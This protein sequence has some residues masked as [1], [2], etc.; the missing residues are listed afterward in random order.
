MTRRETQRR[1]RRV[2]DDLACVPWLEVALSILDRDTLN[3]DNYC[4]K[5]GASVEV[6]N[7]VEMQGPG[8]PLPPWI[9]DINT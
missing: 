5:K 3:I 4:G 2:I 9:S 6:R 8:D 1:I 7:A